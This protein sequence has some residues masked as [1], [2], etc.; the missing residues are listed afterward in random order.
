MDRVKEL[1]RLFAYDDWA[2]R[3]AL[4]TL[5]AAEDLPDR[6]LKVL[7]HV[8]GAERLW[9][10]RLEQSK[11]AAAVWP[12][13][14]LERCEAEI[15]D[16][17]ILWEEYLEDLDPAELDRAVSYVNT[18]GERWSNTAGDVLAHVFLHSAYHRGQIAALLRAGGCEPASTDFIHCVRQGLVE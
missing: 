18:R 10:G 1:E 16:L 5:R 11:S 7:A 12:D 3:E 2:N 14:T 13:L 9:L 8:L 17:V 6:A 15:A 4:A